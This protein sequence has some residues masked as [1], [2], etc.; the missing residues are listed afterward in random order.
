MSGGPG[1]CPFPGRDALRLQAQV[2]GLKVT[3]VLDV[4][5]AS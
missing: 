2:E 1:L 4:L 5:V 3:G